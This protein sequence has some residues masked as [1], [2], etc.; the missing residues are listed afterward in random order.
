MIRKVSAATGI[1]T[2]IAGN[3]RPGDSGD[4]GPATSAEVSPE[5]IAVDKA[6]N[7]I[8]AGYRVRKIDA[9][10]G[11]ISA[12]AGNGATGYSGDLYTGSFSFAEHPRR[13]RRGYR[14]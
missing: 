12:V 6:G 1:I 14:W 4:G 13:R 9:V 11:H 10:T 5:G 7:I 8:L 2:T 3:G